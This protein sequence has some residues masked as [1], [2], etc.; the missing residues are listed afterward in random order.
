[1]RQSRGYYFARCMANQVAGKYRPMSATVLPAYTTQKYRSGGMPN[2]VILT[3][4]LAGSARL[5]DDVYRERAI[6]SAMQSSVAQC[7][8]ATQHVLNCP[9]LRCLSAFSAFSLRIII[10]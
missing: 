8:S 9:A 4:S 6:L 7:C 2:S 1:M 10:A 5:G 3:L